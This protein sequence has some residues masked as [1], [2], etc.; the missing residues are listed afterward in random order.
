MV[1]ARIANPRSK[2]GTSRRLESELGVSIPV[3]KICRMMDRLDKDAIDAMKDLVAGAA[4]KL[5]PEPTSVVFFDCM[6]LLFES[7]EADGLRE[8]GFS[9][10]G[11]HGRT[12]VLLALMSAS[13][14]LSISCEVFPGSV[15]EG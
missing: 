3:Q 7:V 5:L 2:C 12:Q 14:G 10:N 11:R 15:Y 9:K 1:T 8:F 6:T 13:D 4:R